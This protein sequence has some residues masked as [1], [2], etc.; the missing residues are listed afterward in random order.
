MQKIRC[1]VCGSGLVREVATRLATAA[2]SGLLG[3]LVSKS[4]AGTLA[5][6]PG[7]ALGVQLER[8]VCS[9]CGAHYSNIDERGF[10]V[11]PS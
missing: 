4:I 9:G 6:I 1:A 11:N 5:A 7:Y 8:W 10:G 3:L 2:I